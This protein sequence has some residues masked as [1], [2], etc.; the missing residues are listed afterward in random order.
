MVNSLRRSVVAGCLLWLGVF[1]IDARD[2][3]AWRVGDTA[4]QEVVAPVA[5]DVIDATATAARRAEALTKTP[6]IFRVI[7][8]I[9]NTMVLKVSAA[10][11]EAKAGFLIGLQQKFQQTSLNETTIQSSD[12]AA[13]VAA[14]NAQNKKFP[15]TTALAGQWAQGETGL[16]TL[17]N[18]VEQLLATTSRPVRADTE[19]D[20][21]ELGETLRLVP[22]RSSK[23]AVSLD[24]AEQRGTLVPLTS[25]T[26]VT[27]LRGLFRRDFSEEEQ[28]F[29]R[30]LATYI[31][32]NAELDT[33]LTQQARERGVSRV[34]VVVQHYASG[35]PV[36]RRGQVIDTKIKAALTQLNEMLPPE[37][38]SQPISAAAPVKIQ[39]SEPPSAPAPNPPANNFWPGAV[40]AAVLTV[41]LLGIWWWLASRRRPVLTVP[42][43]PLELAP[44]IAEMLKLVV[45]QE[46]A[47]QRREL[48]QTQQIAAEEVVR[49]MH[50][51]NE[52]HAPSQERLA[53]YERRI[54]ELETELSVRTE[55]NRELLKLKIDL[56]RQQI[57]TERRSRSVNFN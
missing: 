22:V 56:L 20:G 2:F 26:T 7:A 40:I 29:A 9:T 43:L 1:S 42:A 30:T 21:F 35:Q 10:F 39:R 57:E 5:L 13:F 45:V 50:R 23:D 19:P 12:F 18:L 36:V 49:L 6:A 46:L 38:V 54:V 11:T 55:E 51:L 47:V 44:Q 16:A 34:A 27:R 28:L 32:P 15:V 53:A 33:N 48:L 17:T 37:P 3:T 25:V 24:K 41:A 4:D 8:S 52:L 14:F 31:H